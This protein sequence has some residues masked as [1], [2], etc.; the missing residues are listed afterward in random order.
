MDSG[1]NYPSYDSGTT[2]ES[3]DSGTTMESGM[4]YPS[5]LRR[6]LAEM[7]AL[8]IG[9][10]S[11]ER[12]AVYKYHVNE[13]S[14]QMRGNMFALANSKHWPEIQKKWRIMNRRRELM[15]KKNNSHF[16]RRS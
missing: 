3:Q 10:N 16:G 2:M 7:K 4:N 14:R 5:Y 13:F 6:A 15:W 12:L 1:M 11:A 8:P 9:T